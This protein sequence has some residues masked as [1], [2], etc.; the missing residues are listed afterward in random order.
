MPQMAN[1]VIKKKDGTT[2]ATWTMLTPSAGDK[3]PARWSQTAFNARANLR[4]TLDMQTRFNTN[5]TARNLSSTMKYPEV[6]T[7]S[8]VEVVTGTAIGNVNCIVPTSMSAT[9]IDEFAAQLANTIKAALFQE[10]IVTGY[11]AS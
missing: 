1:I 2:D 10:C 7:V 5:R 6:Q 9:A 4:P 11:A 8:G 3:T